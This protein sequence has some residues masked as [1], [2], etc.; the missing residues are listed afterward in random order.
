M[1]DKTSN[2]VIALLIIMIFVVGYYS[3]EDGYK[4]GQD[5]KL[6]EI[7]DNAENFCKDA[8]SLD[9]NQFC[10]VATENYI[11]D[12]TAKVCNDRDYISSEVCTEKIIED[13]SETKKQIQKQIQN[14][15]L[16][17]SLFD[18]PY[19]GQPLYR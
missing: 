2:W 14:Q 15:E 4:Q 11:D 18:P 8:P 1:E 5:E 6:T 19:K 9:I 17:E 13:R 10:E 7:S 12:N 3:Y 16:M